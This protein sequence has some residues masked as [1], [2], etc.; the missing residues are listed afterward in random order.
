MFK[1]LFGIT[2][3]ALLLARTVPAAASSKRGLVYIPSKIH[4]EDDQIWFKTA[5]DGV[6]GAP[7][8]GTNTLKWYYSYQSLPSTSLPTLKSMNNGDLEFVP[9]LWGDYDNT[10]IADVRKLK[11]QGYLIKSV[12]P[13]ILD[14]LNM[15]I[16]R[17]THERG[18]TDTSWVS[19]SQICVATGEEVIS[20][21]RRLRSVGRRTSSH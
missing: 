7:P 16:E 9:M 6:K 2:Y 14:P 5:D 21:P 3:L 20:R 19:M 8:R 15:W 13:V 4:P 11:S 17:L 10:F 18:E 12:N 1:L